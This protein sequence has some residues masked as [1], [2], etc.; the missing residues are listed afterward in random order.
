[1]GKEK[2]VFTGDSLF[3]ESIGR[4]DFPGGDIKGFCRPLEKI[5]FIIR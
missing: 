3:R 4:T 2:V 1:M 5:F